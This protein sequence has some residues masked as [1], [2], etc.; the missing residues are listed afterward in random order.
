MPDFVSSPANF[1]HLLLSFVGYFDVLPYSERC[2]FYIP[3][4]KRALFITFKTYPAKQNDVRASSQII[5]WYAPDSTV[6]ALDGGS[7]YRMSI[8][9]NI[10]VALSNLMNRHVPRHYVCETHVACH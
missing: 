1:C 4:F 10:N 2:T 8:L 3:D 9:T 7:P 5:K 6:E